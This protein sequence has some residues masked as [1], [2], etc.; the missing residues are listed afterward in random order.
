MLGLVAILPHV[1]I[2]KSAGKAEETDKR[3]NIIFAL[4]CIQSN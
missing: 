1:I 2:V 4:P 3:I